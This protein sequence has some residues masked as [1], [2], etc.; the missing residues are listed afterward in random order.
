MTEWWKTPQ[1]IVQTN[2][3]LTDADLDP[4]AVAQS[5]REF[6]ATA[7]L[8]NVGGIFSWYPSE[9]PLQAANP[10]LDRDLVADMIEAAHAADIRVIGRYDLSKATKPAYD[11][12]PDWFCHDVDGVPFEYNGTYQACVNGGW[13][14]A[15][16]PE[17]LKETLSR[18]ALDG[19]FFNMFGY[20]RNDYSYRRLGVCHC[21]GCQSA[22]RD[23]AGMDLPRSYDPSEPALRAYLRFQ[24]STSTA[25][26]EEFRQLA[27]QIRP[28]IAVSNTGKSSDFFRGEINRRL[29]RANEWEHMSGEQARSFRSIGANRIRYSSAV[30]HFVD[31]PWRYASE[32][33]AQQA[34]RL[35]QQLANGADPHYYFMGLPEQRDRE[36][37]QE[38]DAIFRMHAAH[39]ARYADL[40]SVAT[41]A[42]YQSAK[43]ARY[44]NGTETA[45][46][47]G[48]YKALIDSGLPFDIVHDSRATD[49]DFVDWHGRYDV[50]VLAGA[51]CISAEE[52][53]SLDAYV[54]AGG[55]LLVIGDAGSHDETGTAQDSLQ[56][57]S[58]PV[59]GPVSTR[60]SL[61]GGYLRLDTDKPLK[62]DTDVV[63]LDGPYVE[64]RQKAGTTGTHRIELPQR[65]GPPE[66]CYPEPDSDSDLPGVVTGDHGA[67]K[68]VFIPW[69]AAKLYHDFRLTP[70]RELLAQLTRELAGEMPAALSTTGHTELTVQRQTTTGDLLVHVV[71]YSGVSG[72]GCLPPVPIH[73]L[74]LTV[75]GAAG[76]RCVSLVSGDTLPV[77]DGTEA[78]AAVVTLPP[79]RAF[80]VL[81]FSAQA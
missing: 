33:G 80:D 46:F 30:T 35:A 10:F 14:R 28:D 25:L 5:L 23:F 65:F 7:M 36:P 63:L 44:G 42:L 71:N 49:A 66:L 75:R 26:R 20:Q 19:L 32:S 62:A 48:A 21:K 9:L 38:V 77:S 41:I 52:A 2:L 50:I 78:G 39:V 72:D 64:L 43:S 18:Y 4:A 11:Q 45:A 1:R 76:M 55:A 53:A 6:G 37:M 57:Q 24:D 31:Y 51:S 59:T 15:Q 74:S 29:D 56:L 81:A 3:R 17:V 61:R 73:D 27:K 13:Y 54:N 68:V 8:F 69:D 12:N 67:G 40:D 22:F 47:R 79:V 58:L 70:H 16:S 34:L 60:E